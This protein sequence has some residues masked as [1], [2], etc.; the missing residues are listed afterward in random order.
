MKSRVLRMI[1]NA[2]SRRSPDTLLVVTCPSAVSAAWQ[3]V[4]ACWNTMSGPQARHVRR[5]SYAVV[6]R[7]YVVLLLANVPRSASTAAR[8]CT[9]RH[10]HAKYVSPSA[11]GQCEPIT[12]WLGV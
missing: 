10:S 2:R 7:V 12:Y 3:Y 5:L 11:L 1:A 4:Y 8:T 6:S 9:I